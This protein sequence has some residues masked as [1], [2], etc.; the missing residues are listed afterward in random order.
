[1]YPFRKLQL[2]LMRSTH[3]MRTIISKAVVAAM[4]ASAL[5]APAFA[6]T[7]ATNAIQ[8]TTTQAANYQLGV[9]QGGLFS[10]TGN[11][12]A[13]VNIPTIDANEFMKKLLLIKQ[14]MSLAGV[15]STVLAPSETSHA[16]LSPEERASQ[17]IS[18]GLIRF[19]VGIENK[20]DLITDLEQA[21]EAVSKKM[22]QL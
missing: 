16:L 15:E 6:N 14:S 10:I 9:T 2:K 11:G 8:L 22:V 7:V 13:T 5:T 20:N 4:A 19:S 21:F 12:L 17:G 18:D 3:Q 1:M